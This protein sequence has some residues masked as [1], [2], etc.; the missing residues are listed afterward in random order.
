MFCHKRSVSVG[1][2]GSDVSEYH[3]AP[4]EAHWC[5]AGE[6]QASGADAPAAALA[7]A[8]DWNDEHQML[9]PNDRSLEARLCAIHSLRKIVLAESDTGAE[10]HLFLTPLFLTPHPQPPAPSWRTG[11][12]RLWSAS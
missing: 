3:D 10:S 11:R 4:A 2:V 8:V 9:P 5:L 7:V 12:T 6:E 1:S